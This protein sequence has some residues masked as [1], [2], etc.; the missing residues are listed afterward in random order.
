MLSPVDGTVEA[1]NRDVK[2]D[3]GIVNDDPYGRGWLLE[4]RPS[5]GKRCCRNLMDS[6]LAAL[7][8]ADNAERVARLYTP[9]LGGM[10]ADGGEPV[11]GFGRLLRPDGW[12]ELAE[13][14]FLSSDLP[15]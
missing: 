7:W 14:A 11:E 2:L 3:P 5:G 8:A 15:S 4:V 6:R 1:V 10:L 9:E 12:H 13:D